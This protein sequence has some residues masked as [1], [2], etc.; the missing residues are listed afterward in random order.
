MK[1]VEYHVRSINALDER[2]GT[3]VCVVSNI[4]RWMLEFSS[5]L[6][7]RYLVGK[8]GKTPYERMKGTASQMLGLE[9]AEAVMFRRVPT[10]GRLGKLDSLW[11]KGLLVGYKSTSGEYMVVNGEGAC[12][13]RTVRRLPFEHRWNK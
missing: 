4:L 3:D 13:T 6:L 8:D 12:R 9:F 10:P 7:N 1:D 5:V 11:E 2:A